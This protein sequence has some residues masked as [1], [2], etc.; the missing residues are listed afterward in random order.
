MTGEVVLICGAGGGLG[1][2]IVRHFQSLGAQVAAIDLSIDHAQQALGQG[3]G[4]A[5]AA[6]LTDA[7]AVDQILDQCVERFG[8][9]DHLV[10]AAGVLSVATTPELSDEEWR[11]S[12]AVNVDAVFHASRA[13][14]RMKLAA[15]QGGSIVNIAS[16]SGLVGMPDRPAY[17]STKHAVVGLT[18]EMAME[19]GP[20]GL[21][22]NAVA[23]GIVRTPLTEAHFSNPEIH[24]RI[25]RA[26]P[27]GR[28]ARPEEIAAAVGFLCSDAASYITGVILP[29]DG[30]YTAGKAW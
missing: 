23:P 5:M 29:V 4:V 13:F 22:V 24:E 18:R 6:D 14:A 2:A 1:T 9:V 7:Q 3:N 27:L 21:R 17:I 11:L 26:Y 16:I 10:N 30:G 12:F 25:A 8:H 20:R 19:F 15:G 28:A